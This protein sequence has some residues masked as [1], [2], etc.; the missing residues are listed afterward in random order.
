MM[1][2]LTGWSGSRRRLEKDVDLAVVERVVEDPV[3]GAVRVEVAVAQGLLPPL[4]DHD[5]GGVALSSS[6]S[7]FSAAAALE[8]ARLPHPSQN[9]RMRLADDVLSGGVAPDRGVDEP[10]AVADVEDCLF[11][12]E[13]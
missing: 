6:S 1:L 2:H 8:P 11:E 10:E 12:K 4:G 7:S 3:E 9:V 5:D 13:F